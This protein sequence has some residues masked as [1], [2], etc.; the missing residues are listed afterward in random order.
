MAIWNDTDTPRAFLITFRTYGTWLHGDERGSIDRY[1]NVFRSP[2]LPENPIIF[3]QHQAKLKTEPFLLNA[4]ARSV[5]KDSIKG[6]CEY[7]DWA[8]FALH[9]RTN[10][11]HLVVAY[12]G[13]S[14][15]NILRDIKAYSTRALRKAGL[16]RHDHSPWTDGG[17]KRYLWTQ[18]SIGNACD[19]VVNG[20]GSDL[21]ES[22]D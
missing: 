3:R 4:E 5:V 22:F 9:I 6:V 11:G 16:W 10:H 15:D 8:L 21:P 20:Q 7:R 14:P 2:R 18:E 17:S 12:A 1:H 13:T 19:Y